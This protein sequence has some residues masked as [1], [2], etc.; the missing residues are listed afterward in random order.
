MVE[1]VEEKTKTGELKWRECGGRVERKDKSLGCGGEK[2][3]V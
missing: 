1:N 3:D 2:V